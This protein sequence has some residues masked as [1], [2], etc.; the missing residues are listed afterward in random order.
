MERMFQL[1]IFALFV[2]NIGVNGHC[3]APVNITILENALE[4]GAVCLDGSP[5]GYHF[6]KGFG[7]GVDN[8]I[9]YLPGGGWCDTTELCTERVLKKPWVAS[10]K[11]MTITHFEGILSSTQDCN[12]D[13]YNWNKVYL[14][15]CDGSSFTGDVEAVDPATN[16]HYRGSRIFSGIVNEMLS[17]G[18]NKAQNVILAG[19]SA[20][21]LATMLN[22][23]RFRALVPN[24]S[25]VKCFSDSGFFIHGKHLTNSTE[26]EKGFA[27]VVKLHGITKFLPTSCTS[28]MDP[29]LCFFPENFV[30]DIQ[31]PLFLLNSDFDQYQISVTLKPN[32]A[33]KPNWKNCTDFPNTETCTPTQFQT[34]KDF[35]KTFLETLKNVGDCPSRGLFINSCYIHDHIFLDQRWYSNEAPR[36][37]NKTIA[38]AFGDWYFD[39]SIVKLV[40]YQTDRPLVCH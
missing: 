19:N 28:R 22:C 12:P 38:Q 16:L 30:G 20:G 34:I 10:T 27:G 18:L 13:F 25:R 2:M 39:R 24:A 3:S 35:G 5:A 14:R 26:R 23:D 32:P 11:N 31:T 21:G 9:V 4:T 37:D 40:D 6:S 15:Y 8:W 33:D 7:D 1:L 29:G 36:L 17:K